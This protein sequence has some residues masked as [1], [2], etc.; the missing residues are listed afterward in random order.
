MLTDAQVRINAGI[1]RR[2]DQG[3]MALPRFPNFLR[4]TN[5]GHVDRVPSFVI[6]HQHVLRLDISVDV[7][8]GVNVLE[9]RDKLVREQQHR[10]ER[11]FSIA[12]IEK[13]LQVWAKKLECHHPKFAFVS[14]P[15]YPRD[16]RSTRK[17]FV[18]LDFVLEKRRVDI[19]M[20]EFQGDFL[21]S[22]EVAS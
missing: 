8:L 3:I 15:V 4:Q 21:S 18:D 2:T 9:G 6:S 22:L 12:I 19:C 17:F 1:T 5:V 7:S 16:A 14:M 20:L 11:E 10:L 13:I